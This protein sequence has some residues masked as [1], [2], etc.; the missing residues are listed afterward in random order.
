[1]S[2]EEAVSPGQ[3]KINDSDHEDSEAYHPTDEYDELDESS[4]HGGFGSARRRSLEAIEHKPHLDDVQTFNTIDEMKDAVREISL[5]HKT[6][7]LVMSV[8]E[9]AVDRLD[10]IYNSLPE[11]AQRHYLND[12][13]LHRRIN[14]ARKA[15]NRW[16]GKYKREQQIPSSAEAGPANY[17]SKKARKTSRYAREGREE[18]DERVQKIKSGAKGGKQRAL[19]EIGSSVAEQT[20][21]KEQS[22]KEALRELIDAD[23][24][25]QYRNPR[26]QVGVVVRVNKKSVRL[27]R[28]NPRY[29]GKKPMSDEAE[30]EY[31]KET[32]DLKARG[33]TKIGR[34]DFEDELETLREFHEDLPGDFDAAVAHISGE[35]VEDEES[36]GETED[37][38]DTEEEPEHWNQELV[39]KL[40]DEGIDKRA[41]ES[42][43]DAYDTVDELLNYTNTQLQGQ[44]WVGPA[45]TETI[46]SV[47]D[48]RY[49][50]DYSIKEQGDGYEISEWTEPADEYIDIRTGEIALRKLISGDH[51]EHHAKVREKIVEWASEQNRSDDSEVAQELINAAYSLTPS[52]INFGELL[53]D[54][55][56]SEEDDDESNSHWEAVLKARAVMAFCD[57]TGR[58]RLLGNA[59]R[60][61]TDEIE[62][63]REEERKLVKEKIEAESIL[64]YGKKYREI[65]GWERLPM[66]SHEAKVAYRGWWKGEPSITVLYESPEFVKVRVFSLI[67]WVQIEWDS[68]EPAWELLD[69]KFSNPTGSTPMNMI[70]GAQDLERFLKFAPSEVSEAPPTDINGWIMTYWD[71]GEKAVYQDPDQDAVIK[72]E[73]GRLIL[74]DGFGDKQTVEQ[75]S[76]K[77]ALNNL[78]EYLANHMAVKGGGEAI[79]VPIPDDDTSDNA[80]DEIPVSE[81]EELES[82]HKGWELTEG[83]G[84]HTFAFQHKGGRVVVIERR[85]DGWD[86]DL[87]NPSFPGITKWLTD[88]EARKEQPGEGPGHRVRNPVDLQT[89]IDAAATEMDR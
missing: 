82:A 76:F 70:E 68:G 22:E 71:D 50:D 17:P 19:N 60:E 69:L 11:D 29:P 67:E 56:Q 28:P 5:A 27:I 7:T 40:R 34:D 49:G 6:G 30:P 48:D 37:T 77:E 46:R 36:S 8:P 63:T 1:M 73:H 62:E 26:L 80:E 84:E 38:E 86:A 32:V 42:L 15:F 45:T 25:L 83:G 23:D 13:V 75:D 85:D 59:E 72:A 3:T 10:T 88:A 78:R 35:D 43:A 53:E 47:F 87:N 66:S 9:D 54:D 58:K 79:E 55:E 89:A 4:V 64:K 52:E 51:L 81:M 21:K 2:T 31:R 33:L 57:L 74:E 12:D 24:I 44:K 14:A 16:M 65:A 61:A 39:D 20:A 41:A 18:L